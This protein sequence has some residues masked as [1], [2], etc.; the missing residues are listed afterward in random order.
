MLFKCFVER[1]FKSGRGKIVSVS[2]DGLNDA[3]TF[4]TGQSSSL[5]DAN[6]QCKP[7]FF[8]VADVGINYNA[9]DSVIS[10]VTL[11][12]WK[13][14]TTGSWAVFSA[15]FAS[16]KS[17]RAQNYSASVSADTALGVANN[18]LKAAIASLV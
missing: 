16:A 2:K 7:S 11:L 4:K 5:W 15:A 9:L 6:D 12:R 18:N 3:N 1:S 10:S 8:A 14:Y 17:A 13:D